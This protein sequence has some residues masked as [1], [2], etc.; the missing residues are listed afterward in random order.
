MAT[1]KQVEESYSKICKLLRK[2][3][4]ELLDATNNGIMEKTDSTKYREESVFCTFWD[5]SCRIDKK[6]K[7]PLARAVMSEIKNRRK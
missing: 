2:L 6:I 3:N 7:D 5:L 1:R 4:N